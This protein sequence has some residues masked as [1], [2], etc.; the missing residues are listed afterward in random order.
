MDDASGRD[1]LL[2][3]LLLDGRCSG[4]GGDWQLIAVSAS[5][6]LVSRNMT[7]LL[8]L[9]RLILLGSGSCIAS[10]DSVD[11]SSIPL[12]DS[13]R[14]TLLASGVRETVFRPDIQTEPL[15]SPRLLACFA[16]R[17]FDRIAYMTR[18]ISLYPSEQELFSIAGD[19]ATYIS[20]NAS[21]LLNGVHRL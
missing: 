17:S 21:I 12:L 10:G 2:L 6:L 1:S 5:S 19:Y 8:L 18:V 13:S 3:S 4:S 7:A 16:L 20:R 15:A 14:T 9:P 11:G